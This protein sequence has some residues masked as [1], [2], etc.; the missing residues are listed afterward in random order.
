MRASCDCFFFDFL[1]TKRMR[2]RDAMTSR[3][4]CYFASRCGFFSILILSYTIVC[5]GQYEERV[6]PCISELYDDL[7]GYREGE[8]VLAC[9]FY[10]YK[11]HVV[12]DALCMCAMHKKNDTSPFFTYV[13]YCEKCENVYDAKHVYN[14]SGGSGVVYDAHFDLATWVRIDIFVNQKDVFSDANVSQS[15]LFPSM[16]FPNTFVSDHFFVDCDCNLKLSSNLNRLDF[17]QEYDNARKSQIYEKMIYEKYK[18]YVIPYES[19]E[20]KYDIIPNSETINVSSHVSCFYDVNA[21][22]DIR[23][24]EY[25]NYEKDMLNIGVILIFVPSLTEFQM[26]KPSV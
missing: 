5:L 20:F 23:Y 12:N 11:K 22:D 9:Q 7:M 24:C 19:Y 18:R 4:G 1:E 8:K 16:A 26:P 3:S 10:K 13:R 25:Q 17:V 2:A 21:Y 6:T 14:N 15:V